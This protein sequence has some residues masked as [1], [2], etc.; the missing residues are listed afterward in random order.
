MII[1]EG[2]FDVMKVHQAGF[3]SVIALMGSSLSDTQAALIATNFPRATI[4]LDS[5]EAGE[6]ALPGIVTRLGRMVD[7]RIA[8][9]PPGT[10]PDA[11]PTEMIQQIVQRS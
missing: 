2:F 10:Q 1:V 4:M 8:T 6:Q 3:P 5:D 11:L 7:V 9:L